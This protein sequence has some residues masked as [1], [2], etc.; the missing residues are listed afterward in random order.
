VVVNGREMFIAKD[1]CAILGYVHTYKAV[2]MHCKSAELL[3]ASEM[4][5]LEIGPRGVLIIPE[6]DLYRLIMRS[7]MPDAEEFQ[8]WVCEE[9]LPRIRKTGGYIQGEENIESEDELVLRA[10]AVLQ[11]KVGELRGRLEE[12]HRASK[13]LRSQVPTTIPGSA[14]AG[15][16]ETAPP[17]T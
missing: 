13:P 4:D 3:K 16:P 7:N 14:W 17:T 12:Q 5:G 9:V 1:V 10:M 2:Q 8:D 6:S 15:E 11:R